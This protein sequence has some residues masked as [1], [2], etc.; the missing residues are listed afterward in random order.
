[1]RKSRKFPLVNDYQNCL[2][3]FREL[4]DADAS[5]QENF[6]SLLHRP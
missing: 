6:K 3:T 2:S 1:M 5:G 4:T